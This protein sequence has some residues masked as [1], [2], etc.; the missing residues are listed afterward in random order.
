MREKTSNYRFFCSLSIII[1]IN[2]EIASINRN[3]KKREKKNRIKTT[4][5][6]TCRR[7]RE[8]WKKKKKSSLFFIINWPHH[9]KSTDAAKKEILSSISN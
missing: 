2:E 3:I 1:I 7:E 9:P 8:R 4:F 5:N 6:W